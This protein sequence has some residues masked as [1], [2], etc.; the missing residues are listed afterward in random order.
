VL[1]AGGLTVSGPTA[2]SELYDETSN[3]WT[4]AGGM[5]APREGQTSTS[6]PNGQVV[7]VCGGGPGPEDPSAEVYDPKTNQWLPAAGGMGPS[8]EGHTA[9]LLQD[10]TV[11]VAGGE[12]AVSLLLIALGRE[13][14]GAVRAELTDWPAMAVGVLLFRLTAV[15]AWALVLAAAVTVAR[16]AL[17]ATRRKREGGASRPVTPTR[18]PA[19]R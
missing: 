16:S 14:H 10:G 12:M 6:L 11:L 17:A 8:P 18:V 9:T 4:P 3:S 13:P 7:G 19:H 1:V 15:C 2:T 5:S